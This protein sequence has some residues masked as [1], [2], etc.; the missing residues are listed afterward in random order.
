V[1]GALGERIVAV[2]RRALFDEPTPLERRLHD[3]F[4]VPACVPSLAER[5]RART[6][7]RSRKIFIAPCGSIS[8]I[9]C[10]QVLAA[11]V[12]VGHLPLVVLLGE[13]RADEPDARAAVG[14][15]PEL[16]KIPTTALRRRI[17]RFKRSCGLVDQI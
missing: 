2:E 8:A 17:S 3:V 5:E 6:L 9:G 15:D 1:P 16:G 4:D 14:E 13:D 12:P 11:H 7:A 10:V